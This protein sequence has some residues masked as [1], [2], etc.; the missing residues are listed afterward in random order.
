MKKFLFI[1]GLC[2]LALSSRSFAAADGLGCNVSGL[3]T[4]VHFDSTGPVGPDAQMLVLING[5]VCFVT[6][7][8]N[9]L[10]PLVTI[11]TT[12]AATGKRAKLSDT[13]AVI[14]Q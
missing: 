11:L 9:N 14:T 3:V 1:L 2:M 4:Y 6:G 13:S 7:P 10:T 12:A 5:M 8:T